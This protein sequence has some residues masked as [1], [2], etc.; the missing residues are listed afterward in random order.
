MSTLGDLGRAAWRL[1]VTDGVPSSGAH[2][3]QKSDILAFVEELE[4]RLD[5]L[6]MS[7]TTVANLPAAASNA[8]AVIMVT[9][10]Q[11]P[12]STQP[13][14]GNGTIKVPVF[15]NGAAW[16]PMGSPESTTGMPPYPASALTLLDPLTAFG[17]SFWARAGDGSRSAVLDL[18]RD[19]YAFGTLANESKG[20]S[21]STEIANRVDDTDTTILDPD[22]DL[23]RAE[24]VAG[25]VVID[26]GRNSFAV[27]VGNSSIMTTVLADR[28]RAVAEIT[29]EYLIFTDPTSRTLPIGN[30][31]WAQCEH[32]KRVTMASYPARTVDWTWCLQQYAD[33]DVEQDLIDLYNGMI[34]ST[35]TTYDDGTVDNLHPGTKGNKVI[36]YGPLWNWLRWRAQD[37]IWMPPFHEAWISGSAA[38]SAIVTSGHVYSTPFLGSG[39]AFT[40]VSGDATKFAVNI[41]TGVV[42]CVA[43][44][45]PAAAYYDLVVRATKAGK[46]VDCA[47]RLWIGKNTRGC[48]DRAVSRDTGGPIVFASAPSG[49]TSKACSIIVGVS[50]GTGTDGD[51]M[52]LRGSESSAIALYRDT[53]NKIKFVARN[54][55]GTIIAS[56][57]SS[58]TF[59]VADGMKWIAVSVNLAPG[60]PTATMYLNG[61]SILAGGS[62]LTSGGTIDWNKRGVILA[63]SP[64]LSYC[65]EG[66]L[67]DYW[68][69]TSY[70]DWSSSSRRDERFNSGTGAAVTLPAGGAINSITPL[71]WTPGNLADL[72]WGRCGNGQNA[73]TGPAGVGCARHYENPGAGGQVDGN[74]TPLDL[75][76]KLLAWWNAD[77]YGTANMTVETGDRLTAWVDRVA[78][79]TL[80]QSSGNAA[81]P[82][83]IANFDATGLAVVQGTGTH[84]MDTTS[85]SAITTGTTAGRAFI[86]ASLD[87]VGT[88]FSYGTNGGNTLR[89]ITVDGNSR[90]NASDASLT[91]QSST[92]VLWN[93]WRVVDARFSTAGHL[94]NVDGTQVGTSAAAASMNTGTTRF[95][96]LANLATTAAGFSGTSVRHLMFTT[97]TL[98]TDELQK[99]Q[100]W[101]AWDQGRNLDLPATH[102]YRNYRP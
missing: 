68:C 73:G 44:F 74:F 50:C 82:T 12:D 23:S 62:T 25:D 42:T 39:A 92:D 95:R 102:P 66:T 96:F 8:G 22:A 52:Y 5:P 60:S 24:Q 3:P 88:L 75:G 35:T 38:D 6:T 28:D 100:G 48:D 63:D 83:W 54:S 13:V 81:R 99:L 76:V 78:G 10:A 86:S 17:H 36:A 79:V 51:K 15:S 31:V 19:R 49:I 16:Y 93:G 18:L 1:F 85:F 20:G 64:S 59:T 43:G 84:W 57:T 27:T 56:L 21:T 46:S 29:G 33:E 55:S 97:D 53:D 70:I 41:A 11:A 4:S 91:A 30:T 2:E 101:L 32:Y 47:L 89:R 14:V 71:E 61:T 9:D 80:A 40:L 45:T 26:M 72:Y 67:R 77:D 7:E 94:L 69:A 34:P 90:I 65:W 37:S 87:V 58:S 98:T